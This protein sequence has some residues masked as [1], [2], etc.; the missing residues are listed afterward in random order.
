[1]I[2]ASADGLCVLNDS[3]HNFRKRCTQED[4]DEIEEWTDRAA[5]RMYEGAGLGLEDVDIFNPYDRYAPPSLTLPCTLKAVVDRV[6]LQT[7][8]TGPTGRE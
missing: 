6:C 4:L 5:R 7:G 2:A 8:R 1:M 3:Q